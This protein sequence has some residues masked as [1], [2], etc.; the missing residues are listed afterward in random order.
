MSDLGGL[1]SGQLQVQ[2]WQ[3]LGQGG[4]VLEHPTVAIAVFY[5]GHHKYPVELT[6]SCDVI[7]KV[8]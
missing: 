6:L 7:K 5:L 8:L 2:K 4:L 3:K 1:G